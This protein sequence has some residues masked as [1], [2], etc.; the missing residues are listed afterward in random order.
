MQDTAN[1]H[2]NFRVPQ[3]GQWKNEAEKI[4]YGCEFIETEGFSNIETDDEGEV[5]VSLMNTEYFG[6]EEG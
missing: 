5:D 4:N 1:Y 2:D 6:E 3:L